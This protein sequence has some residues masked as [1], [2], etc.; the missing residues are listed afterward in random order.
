MTD[1]FELIAPPHA[2]FHADGS[3]HL[4]MI[5]RQAEH[6]LGTGISAVFVSGTTGESPSLTVQER[7]AIAQRWLDVCRKTE[8]GVIV[9]VGHNS[10]EEARVMAA[11][12][13]REGADAIATLTPSFLKP[14]SVDDL[15]ECCRPVA[16]AAP[17]LPLYV[18]DIPV[19]SNVRLPMDQFLIRGKE[20]IPS[21]KG[22]KHTNPDLVH[23]QECLAANDGEFEILFGCDE[24]L[25]S[26]VMFGCPGAVGSTYNFAA[27]YYAEM[28]RAFFAGDLAT[29][30]RHQRE[31]VRMIRLLQSYGF[32]PAAKTVMSF[33]GIDCGPTRYPLRPLTE[34]QQT[35]LRS[36]VEQLEAIELSTSEISA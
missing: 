33:L 1:Q 13:Q 27:P 35:R 17:D 31:A 30:R 6:F 21:L 20:Q 18:Y 22:I 32:H 24:I 14:T 16:E 25:L 4:A 8:L 23:L 19:L 2:P 12:A 29:A 28:I 3:L 5:E 36:E 26:A 7:L 9:M 11:H 15:I 10:L 34:A